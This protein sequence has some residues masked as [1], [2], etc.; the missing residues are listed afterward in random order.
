M[1]SLLLS[2]RDWWI[3]LPEWLT[4]GAR[5]AAVAAVMAVLALNLVLPANLDQAKAEALTILLT[6]GAAAIAIVR[7]EIL[8]NILPW[9]LGVPK[10]AL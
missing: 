9:I 8:P 7:V 1:R 5:D 2:I 3:S 6:A 4:K 10:S